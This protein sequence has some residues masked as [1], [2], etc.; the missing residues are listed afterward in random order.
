[1]VCPN[2][3]NSQLTF[4]FISLIPEDY[5]YC[6]IS[7]CLPTRTPISHCVK[8][9]SS[10]LVL[11]LGCI[12]LFHLRCVTSRWHQIPV[13][14]SEVAQSPQVS[15]QRLILWLLFICSLQ[16]FQAID[17]FIIRS[18]KVCETNMSTFK[19]NKL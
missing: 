4:M 1:M 8:V 9:L 17:V 5:F 11:S 14:S 19:E 15:I 10:Q 7:F 3:E 6:Q 18:V 12:G 2:S 13:S 16:L